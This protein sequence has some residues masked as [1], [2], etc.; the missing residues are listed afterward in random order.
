MAACELHK[1]KSCEKMRK[2]SVQHQICNGGEWG[3]CS[4]H[5]D[6]QRVFI[7]AKQTSG[8]QVWLSSQQQIY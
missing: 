4:V 8:L 3:V 5:M 7:C 6:M 2:T 1:E